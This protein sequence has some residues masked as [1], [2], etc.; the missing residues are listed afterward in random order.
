M[1]NK[2]TN[3]VFING[4]IYIGSIILLANSGGT[5][6]V[7]LGV[8]CFIMLILMYASALVGGEK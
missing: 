8:I 5:S 3:M 7:V 2:L 1:N 4:V 6:K